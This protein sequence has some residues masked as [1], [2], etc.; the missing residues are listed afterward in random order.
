MILVFKERLRTSDLDVWR[1]GGGEGIGKDET[2][3]FF[4]GNFHL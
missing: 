3:N 1:V 4:G 2:E